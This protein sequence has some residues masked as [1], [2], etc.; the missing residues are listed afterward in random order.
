MLFNGIKCLPEDTRA[1][2]LLLSVTALI[3]IIIFVIFVIFIITVASEQV[4]RSKGKIN[5]QI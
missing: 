1:G 2:T 3:F 4:K 5:T